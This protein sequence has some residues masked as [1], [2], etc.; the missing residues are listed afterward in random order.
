MRTDRRDGR[1][2]GEAASQPTVR[3]STPAAAIAQ[4]YRMLVMRVIG[5]PGARWVSQYGSTAHH[6]TLPGREVRPPTVAAVRPVMAK[7]SGPEADCRRPGMPGDYL[8]RK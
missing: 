3:V 7:V 2:A 6:G 5:G 8:R 4:G 1:S